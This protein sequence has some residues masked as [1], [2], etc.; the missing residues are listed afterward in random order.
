MSSI[1][2][3]LA[4]GGNPLYFEKVFLTSTTWTVPVTGKYLVTAIGGGGSGAAG[5]QT[6]FFIGSGA[7][8]GL[9]QALVPLAAGTVLTITCGAGG[10]AVAGSTTA[11]AGNNGG[12]TTVTGDVL[13][14]IANGGQGGV[15]NFNTTSAS[16]GT[17]SNGNVMNVTGGNGRRGGGAVGV[18]GTGYSGGLVALSG[19]GTGG[20]P[21]DVTN[22]YPG[23]GLI[24]GLEAST[25]K[26]STEVYANPLKIIGG[27]IITG[28]KSGRLLLPSGGIAP[29]ASN[30]TVVGPGCGAYAS[31]VNT[32]YSF[33]GIFAGGYC[34]AHG[35]VGSRDGGTLGGGGGGYP[36]TT[37]TLFSGSGGQGGVIIEFCPQ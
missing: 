28:F 7:A 6:T 22:G 8:G 5:V 26:F 21:E 1:S 29:A 17:A 16:G 9:A 25:Y 34:A 20:S 33:A 30:E 11:T 35:S 15:T 13:N 10:A 18:Y 23:T 4:S 2:Q 31:A 32:V 19:A 27:G 24:S 12:T 3:F 36:G 37:T 14:L